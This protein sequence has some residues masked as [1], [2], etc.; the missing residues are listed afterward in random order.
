MVVVT[1]GVTPDVSVVVGGLHDFDSG[2]PA[3]VGYERQQ[4]AIQDSIVA[5]DRQ[6]R[7]H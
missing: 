7:Q 5:G 4:N 2:N 6:C 1:S 3:D